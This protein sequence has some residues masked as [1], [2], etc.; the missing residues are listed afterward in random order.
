VEFVEAQQR[1]IGGRLVKIERAL[2]D[3]V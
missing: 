1:F 2:S 3:V